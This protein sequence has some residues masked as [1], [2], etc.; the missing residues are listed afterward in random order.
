MT[1]NRQPIATSPV[2]P[3]SVVLPLP[4]RSVKVGVK[5]LASIVPSPFVSTQLAIDR[6]GVG[7]DLVVVLRLEDGV[8]GDDGRVPGGRVVAREVGR[9]PGHVLEV[10][11]A[12]VDPTEV[13]RDQ[14]QEQQDREDERELD[15]ALAEGALAAARRGGTGR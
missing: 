12:Q 8:V 6:L 7:D 3:M 15:E 11:V 4:L 14:R 9:D 1:W 13:E 5:S 10:D 2:S